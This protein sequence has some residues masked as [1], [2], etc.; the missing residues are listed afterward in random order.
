MVARQGFDALMVGKEKVVG[1]SLK[2]NAPENRRT[3]VG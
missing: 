3:R 1:G 2:N